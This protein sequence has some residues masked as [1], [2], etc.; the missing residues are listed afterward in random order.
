MFGGYTNGL[1]ENEI[2]SLLRKSQNRVTGISLKSQLLVSDKRLVMPCNSTMLSVPTHCPTLYNGVLLDSFQNYVPFPYSFLIP[3]RWPQ[4]IHYMKNWR[5]QMETLSAYCLQTNRLPTSVHIISS[6]FPISSIEC[7]SF[8]LNPFLPL[9]LWFWPL[10]NSSGT[11][12]HSSFSLL[13]WYF[14]WLLLKCSV[15]TDKPSFEHKSFS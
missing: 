6:L 9:V 11:L 8:S 7:H 5:Y 13:Y 14:W 4:L 2:S 15:L 10:Q 1:P 3:G 12:P